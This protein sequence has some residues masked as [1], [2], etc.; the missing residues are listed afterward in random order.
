MRKVWFLAAV[1]WAAGAASA[2][3]APFSNGDFE[4]GPIIA[5]SP[6]IAILPQGDTSLGPWTIIRSGVGY[7][8]SAWNAHD[9][10]F[11]LTLTGQRRRSGIRQ[12]FDTVAGALYEVS[13]WVAALPDTSSDTLDITANGTNAGA[14][15]YR[16]VGTTLLNKGRY[17]FST[18][19]VTSGGVTWVPVSFAFIADGPQATLTFRGRKGSNGYGP[20]LDT[21]SLRLLDDG[22]GNGGVTVVPLPMALPLF[23]AGLG[24]LGIIRRRRPAARD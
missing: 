1:L 9:G 6:G 14:L 16:V 10:G 11:S 3:A 12:T 4:T 15:R 20:G 19:S 13:F 21:I 7:V 2:T 17:K 23:A 18:A 24:A 8:G 22:S 5:S